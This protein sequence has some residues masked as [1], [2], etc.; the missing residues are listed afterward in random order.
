VTRTLSPSGGREQPPLRILGTVSLLVLLW[1]VAS[2]L[3]LR[4][5]DARVAA[6]LLRYLACSAGLGWLLAAGAP[7]RQRSAIMLP[8]AMRDFAVAAGIAASAFG[9]PAAAPLGI[10]GILVLVFGTVAVYIIR[11]H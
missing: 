4:A 8:T 5:S 11:R 2:E 3:Q 1:E 10:Y 9:A 7:P 6:A